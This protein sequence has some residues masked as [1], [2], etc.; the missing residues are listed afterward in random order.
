MDEGKM[1]SR[2]R[3]LIDAVELAAGGD[4]HRARSML[5]DP[6]DGPFGRLEAAVGMFVR[7]QARA[8]AEAQ[9]TAATAQTEAARAQETIERQR[10][11]LSEISTPIV[12]VWEGVLA[13]PLVGAV[14]GARAMDTTERLLERIVAGRA[15]FVIVD[16]TGIGVADTATADHLV[17][18]KQAA[19]LLGAHCVIT[20]IGPDMAR[21]LVGLGVTFGDLR[22]MRTLQDG[23]R[24]CLAAA[25]TAEAK[26][27]V[28]A[29]RGDP[30]TGLA[31]A[32]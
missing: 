3:N 32:R 24:H 6:G 1:D 22:T 27:V 29:E 12:D 16:L 4:T 23:L 9:R 18:M 19:R 30:S 20:G 10:Q 17:K 5:R 13:V 21:T 15:R 14:D 26:V 2:L 25:R 8:L 31:R 28:H 7:T 11:S